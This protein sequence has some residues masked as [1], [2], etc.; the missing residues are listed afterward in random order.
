VLVLA[1][2][3]SLMLKEVPLRTQSGLEAARAE[4]SA[5]DGDMPDAG[6]ASHEAESRSAL[7]K[8]HNSG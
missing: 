4:A 1:F 7:V 5:T 6:G 8:P 2:L 3:L